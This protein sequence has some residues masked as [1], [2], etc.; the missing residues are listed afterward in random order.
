MISSLVGS[1]TWGVGKWSELWW[2]FVKPIYSYINMFYQLFSCVC[3]EASL[4]TAL[5]MLHMDC[6]ASV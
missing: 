5:F 3:I 2:N 4:Y 6:N 1:G